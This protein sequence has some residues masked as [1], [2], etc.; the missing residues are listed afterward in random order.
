MYSFMDRGSTIIGHIRQ[1]LPT[2]VRSGGSCI[3]TKFHVVKIRSV[4]NKLSYWRLREAWKRSSFNAPQVNGAFI[5]RRVKSFKREVTLTPFCEEMWCYK[6]N[7]I[8]T[9][10]VRNSFLVSLHKGSCLL[11]IESMA[12]QI[13]HAA[14]IIKKSLGT[15]IIGSESYI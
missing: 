11:A 14:K 10:R 12:K 2:Q 8:P 13:E 7:I 1:Y 6:C 5:A 15:N 3:S 9:T 4:K